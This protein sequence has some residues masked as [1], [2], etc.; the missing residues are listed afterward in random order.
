MYY[1][2][3]IDRT[4]LYISQLGISPFFSASFFY[5]NFFQVIL[6]MEYYQWVFNGNA[7]G[8][9]FGATVRKGLIGESRVCGQWMA[10]TSTRISHWWINWD[11]WVFG[12]I[13]GKMGWGGEMIETSLGWVDRQNK[14]LPIAT[15]KYKPFVVS[16]VL[17]E[18]MT[19]EVIAS[20]IDDN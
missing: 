3:S 15:T 10:L 20:W 12:W 16:L 17:F 2:I 19:A 5:R 6:L 18:W 14:C 9:V 13:G 4:A 7:I 11:R 8:L 1:Q